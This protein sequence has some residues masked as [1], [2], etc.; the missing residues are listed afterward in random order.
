MDSGT[1]GSLTGSGSSYTIP[2][3]A[4]STGSGT[5][6]ITI[7]VDAVTQGNAETTA[8]VDYAEIEDTIYLHDANS[9]EFK[10]F[11]FDG[12][13]IPSKDVAS[14]YADIDS[15]FATD[16]FVYA[17]DDAANMIR[18]WD[19]LLNRRSDKDFAPDNPT[20]SHRAM[21]ANDRDLILVNDTDETLE[22][23]DLIDD[24]YDSSLDV[25]LSSGAWTACTRGGDNLFLG[26]NISDVISKLSLTGAA[27]ST[28][29]LASIAVHTV[30]ATS[31]R[32][33]FVHRTT[34]A[35]LAYDFNGNAQT[36]DN[37]ALGA[38]VYEAGFVVFGPTTEPVD[39]VLNITL[40]DTSIDGGDSVDATFTFDKGVTN[41]VAADV[42]LTGGG[43][44]GTLTDNGDNTFTMPITAPSTG[45][46][47][48]TVSVA[49]D[50]V[51]PGNNSDS[52]SFTYT[53]PTAALSFGSETIAN[54]S[55]TVSTAITSL[56]LP[57]ATGGEGT[58]TYSLSPTLPTGITFTASTRLLAGTP[59]G[60]FS[61]ATFTY[62]AEDADGT[63]VS[64]TFTIV[65]AAATSV[66]NAP[67]N[68]SATAAATSM[69]LSWT[70]PSDNGGAAIT[71]YQYRF[72]TGSTAGGTWTDTNSTAT[73]VTISSLTAETEYTFQVRAVNSVG[74]SPASSAVTESTTA[75]STTEANDEIHI[76][77]NT[78]NEVGVVAPDTADGQRAVALRVYDL[79]T[80][81]TNPHGIGID[82]DGN[83]HVADTTGDDVAVIAPDTA[84]GAVAVAIANL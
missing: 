42:T 59:T 34:G 14:G 6:T 57:E 8:T 78:G 67:T 82:G 3:T 63:T 79:P 7:R 1:L 15:A 66:P 19:L 31:N 37:L 62:T 49:A 45:D 18:V 27:D 12:T 24:S 11:D 21:A 35:T 51:D 41:F 46:G 77:D 58:I 39:A 50:A 28:F 70:A 23:Y 53:E 64:L 52:A 26:N 16:E 40:S 22:F 74:N 13:A 71:E 36:G 61:S 4:P 44:K 9:D 33:H 5:I 60:V 73:S 81:I 30:L 32:L 10:A 43:S 83:L 54:Q 72:T 47:T 25:G 55:W 69:A 84:D 76:T 17:F 48:I 80:V 56:T 29:T 20:H 75:A 68:L 65:V 2:L 38:G